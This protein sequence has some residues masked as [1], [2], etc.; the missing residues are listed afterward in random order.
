MGSLDVSIARMMQKHAYVSAQH[1]ERV[2]TAK[3]DALASAAVVSNLL[4][5]SVNGG[6]QQAFVNE[7]RIEMEA[8][9]LGVTISK[10]VKQTSQ[11]LTVVHTFDT[12]L[13]EI[14]DFE[15]W[16]KT[17]EYDCAQIAGTLKNAVVAREQ[18]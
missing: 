3:K 13:K 8:R 17:M 15:N 16:V 11:W 9:A 14:G 18:R 12:A 2:E 6:V 5:E 1:R 7:K 4:V 10:F